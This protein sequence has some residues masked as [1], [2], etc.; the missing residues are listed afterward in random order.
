MIGDLNKTLKGGGLDDHE[1][2]VSMVRLLFCLYTD[3]TGLWPKGL[4]ER[5]ILER[6]SDDGTD[7]GARFGDFVLGVRSDSGNVVSQAG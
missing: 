7:L 5:Y 4:F 3:D 2:S 1:T 6:T